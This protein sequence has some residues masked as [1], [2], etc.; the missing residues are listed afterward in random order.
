MN[1]A[2]RPAQCGPPE[3]P[4]LYLDAAAYEA[5]GNRDAG[6]NAPYRGASKRRLMLSLDSRIKPSRSRRWILARAAKRRSPSQSA[7]PFSPESGAA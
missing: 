4:Y 2:C 5:T 7:P 3:I 6:Q 1:S